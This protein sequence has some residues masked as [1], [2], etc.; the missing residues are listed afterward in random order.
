MIGIIAF[1][2]CYICSF[3]FYIFIIEPRRFR[4]KRVRIPMRGLPVREL[5]ILHLS[6]LHLR[7]KERAKLRFI[8]KLSQFDFDFAVLTGDTID[9]DSG[10]NACRKVVSMLKPRYATL[11]V[12]GAHDYYDLTAWDMLDHLIHFNQP[13]RMSIRNSI[14]KLIE[15]LTDEGAIVL[16]NS[17]FTTRVNS[18]KLT[19]V[20][21]DDPYI[22]RHD[23]QSALREADNDSFRILLVHTP[24]LLREISA[25]RIPLIIAGH[26]H[27]GQV[28]FPAIGAVTTRCSLNP[29]Y[30]SGTFRIGETILHINN[31]LGT[32]RFTGFRL[33]CRPEASLLRLVR[34]E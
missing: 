8:E 34:E 5:R 19:F 4:L 22:E 28:R 24:E 30:A 17:S 1:C 33:F 32:G 26:T 10:I 21:L 9:N 25:R 15:A 31:G 20:G 16:R 14:E 6:D 3:L 12:L 18:S 11:I 27:G 29:K 7:G 13:R 23:L 2:F